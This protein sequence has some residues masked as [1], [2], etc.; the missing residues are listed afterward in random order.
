MNY[1]TY[2]LSGEI[3]HKDIANPNE[4]KIHYFLEFPAEEEKVIL[5]ELLSPPRIVT[6]MKE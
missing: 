2:S 4:E 5:F 1:I 6:L 3:I